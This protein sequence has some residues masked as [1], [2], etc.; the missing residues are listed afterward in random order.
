MTDDLFGD[1][2]DAAFE[3]YDAHR[4]ALMVTLSEFAEA[5]QVG[6]DELAALLQE[7]AVSMTALD[8]VLSVAKPSESGLKMQFDR[9]QRAFGDIIRMSK[10]DAKIRLTQI[11]NA[12][13]A[14]AADL[15][16]D[17]Q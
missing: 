14:A 1:D 5:Q 12:L 7:A 2:E 11:I 6:E 16:E 8:Y 17:E 13:D 4:K 10:K 3:V 15:D 9:F